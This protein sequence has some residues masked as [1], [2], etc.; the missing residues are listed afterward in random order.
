MS[1]LLP[2]RSGSAPVNH[3]ATSFNH[4]RLSHDALL[5]DAE[6]SDS[7]HQDFLLSI[8]RVSVGGM[9]LASTAIPVLQTVS[10]IALKYSLRRM[11]RP[12]GDTLRPILSFRTQQLPIFTA[13]AQSYVLK[14]F[15]QW[16]IPIF[17]DENNDPRVQHG[18]STCLKAV[19]LQHCQA[20]L[21]LLSERCGAQG[22]FAYNQM[23]RLHVSPNPLAHY[24][25]LTFNPQSE[26]RGISVAEGDILVLSIR[27]CCFSM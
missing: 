10:Y 2:Y 9:A 25:I 14:S 18:I 19:M 23:S 22:L 27:M 17:V 6:Q 13:L 1:R 15:H 24:S 5:G 20:S 26:M 3:A 4:V 7:A 21:L 11:V 8:W 16:A 12:Q